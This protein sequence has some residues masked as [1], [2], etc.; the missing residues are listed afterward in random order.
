[1]NHGCGCL[2][3]QN[4]LYGQH[5]GQ[6]PLLLRLVQGE[7]ESCAAIQAAQGGPSLDRSIVPLRTASEV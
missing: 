6:V 5:K 1:V 2:L 3:F 4:R 7:G